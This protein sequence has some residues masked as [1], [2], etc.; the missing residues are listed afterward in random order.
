MCD[1]NNAYIKVKGR[2]T[3]TELAAGVVGK[4]V[5]KNCAPFRTCKSL[6]NNT[7]VDEADCIDMVMPMY[8]L[9]EYTDNYAK[10][11]GSSSVFTEMKSQQISG[12]QP[13]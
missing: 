6:I 3:V 5:F 2:V 7:S 4:F 12:I 11:T 13:H 8:N 10:T 1:F 9:L